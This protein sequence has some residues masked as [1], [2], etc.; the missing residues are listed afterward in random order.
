MTALLG[1]LWTLGKA[2]WFTSPCRVGPMQGQSAEVTGDFSAFSLQPEVPSCNC[3]PSL[4]LSLGSQQ[5]ICSCVSGALVFLF[6][7]L[8]IYIK[9]KL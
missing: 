2:F 3:E 9:C 4:V 8:T 5:G 7:L 1:Y 6:Y